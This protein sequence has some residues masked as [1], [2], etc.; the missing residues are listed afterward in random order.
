[1]TKKINL[2][3]AAQFCFLVAIII[4]IQ[5]YIYEIPLEAKVVGY[6]GLALYVIHLLRTE[7]YDKKRLLALVLLM[8]VICAAAYY[9]FN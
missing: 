1:M 4:T 9:S 5:H 8:I 3:M 2:E 6:V 7:K